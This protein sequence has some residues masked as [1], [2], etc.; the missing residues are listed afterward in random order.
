MLKRVLV[1]LDGS[2]VAE[3]AIKYAREITDPSEGQ[4][5]LLSAID[6]PEYPASAFYPTVVAYE[7]NHEVVTEQLVP[8]ANEYLQKVAESLR[9]SGFRVNVETVIDEAA[10]A[11]LEKAKDLQVDVIVMSTHGR[12]GLSRWLFGSV[13]NKVLSSSPCPVFIVPVKR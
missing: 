13:A 7:A 10:S 1:P 2:E 4:I 3:R 5:T 8:Q 11:I 6:V 12:S 9:K